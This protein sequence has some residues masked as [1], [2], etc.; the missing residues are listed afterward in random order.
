M[1]VPQQDVISLTGLL[2]LCVFTCMSAC[3]RVHDWMYMWIRMWVGMWVCVW[4]RVYV[5]V[6]VCIYVIVY[7]SKHI[8][9]QVHTSVRVWVHA[10]ANVY[11]SWSWVVCMNFSVSPWVTRSMHTQTPVFR[12]KCN[13]ARN[14]ADQMLCFVWPLVVIYWQRFRD[15]GA[16]GCCYIFVSEFRAWVVCICVF[17]LCF[18]VPLGN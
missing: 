9:T 4:M 16:A 2:S 6:Y 5:C 7:A 3:V 8:H 11:V 18:C 15:S 17:F 13:L 12:Q 14:V 1:A 10:H